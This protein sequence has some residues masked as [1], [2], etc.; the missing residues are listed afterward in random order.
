MQSPSTLTIYI[1]IF[2]HHFYSL[3]HPQTSNLISIERS[4]YRR[5]QCAWPQSS[6]RS[7]RY[8]L[9]IL[10]LKSTLVGVMNQTCGS[11]KSVVN[12]YSCILI[13][14]TLV[15]AFRATTSPKPTIVSTLELS[16]SP[17]PPLITS[18]TSIITRYTYNPPHTIRG[19]K[20]QITASSS[21]PNP[22][23]SALR[24]TPACTWS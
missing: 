2:F 13:N 4:L 12:K 24:R 5:T 10:F 20:Y 6:L 11:I 9:V 19:P 16:I 3:T 18:H 23:S 8:H 7:S 21:R 17:S 14:L 22:A 1:Y 15:V